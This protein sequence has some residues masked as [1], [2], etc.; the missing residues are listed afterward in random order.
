MQHDVHPGQSRH[1]GQ[2]FC[3]SVRIPLE[4]RVVRKTHPSLSALHPS[5]ADT[6]VLIRLHRHG[7]MF[8]SS[9]PFAPN[10]DTHRDDSGANKIE[11]FSCRLPSKQ[12][13]ALLSPIDM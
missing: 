13:T 6:P 11:T 7:A 9:P 2:W 5:I 12:S 10:H 3:P 4:Y 1:H 8:F